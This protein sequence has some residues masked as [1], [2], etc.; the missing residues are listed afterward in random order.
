MFNV[1]QYDREF[2]Q[3]QFLINTEKQQKNIENQR[4]IRSVK[5]VKR[6]NSRVE[7]FMYTT[8]ANPIQ[9]GVYQAPYRIV[10]RESDPAKFKGN[11]SFIL[12]GFKTEKQR[13]KES[14]ENN[15]IL[16][17]HPISSS[18]LSLIYAL[19]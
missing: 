19:P 8:Y 5:L 11:S 16:D 3:Q 14:L 13:I 12:K 15:Q 4:K 2:N 10:P 7:Q 6:Y 17:T 9:I 1:F 18:F